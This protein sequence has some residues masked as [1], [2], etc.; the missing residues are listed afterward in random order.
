MRI[1][2]SIEDIVISRRRL[3]QT[4]IPAAALSCRPARRPNILLVLADDQ[5]Y[6]HAGAHGARNIQTPS[7][8]GIARQGVL[9][10]RSFCTSP[11]CTPSR[12]SIL[13]G[14]YPWQVEQAG[15]LYGTIPPKYPIVTH[16]LA[17][18]GYHAGFTGKGWGPGDWAA[19][20]LTRH[21]N[22]K[23]YNSRQHSIAPHPG[24]DPRDYASN[25]SDFLR[26]RPNG[27]PFFFWL[28]SAE[29][30]R[31]YQKGS[32]LAAGHQLGE[33]T[34]PPYWPD[35]PEVR[36]D[37]LDYI[38]EIEWFDVQ[39]AR[40][41]GVLAS[42]GELENTLIVVTSDNGMPFVRSKVNLYDPGV[43]MPLAIRW[44]GRVAPGRRVSDF[45]QHTDLAPTF[46]AAAGLPIPPSISG[47]SLLPI[48]DSKASGQIEPSRDFA[49]TGM[50]RH[51]MAR[52]DGATYPMR[53][54][55][56]A[57]YLYI[58][59]FAPDRWPTGGPDFLSSNRTPHGDVDAA[60]S[61]DFMMLPASQQ[62]YPEAFALCF[63]KRPA[64]EL[65]RLSS[66]PD[67][68]QNL[69]AN[70]DQQ[71]ALTA[72]R[73]RLEALLRQSS[74]PRIEG[75]DP[76]Q[77]YPYRQTNGFGASFNSTLP[78]ARRQAARQ[79]PRHKPE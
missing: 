25:F 54:L 51:V 24:L 35:T 66:D 9:F 18:A 43:H 56:T 69:A 31:P 76:W 12:S 74:D 52:P 28:G 61:A 33:V 1:P 77:A 3:L 72:H 63:G 67:Q 50:E 22:G 36:G 48:L 57:D 53:A 23:E 38:A 5:S 65:Y 2:D 73:Q 7:F 37:I 47:R 39:L 34:V 60:P 45:V 75:K 29:P 26:E 8:D 16:L 79:E 64:E 27:A 30:H 71:S 68:I 15:V 4:A 59:N 44:G 78:E 11:S 21:P 55:R 49:I 41:L 19:A 46:L 62:Q 20:G 17:D 10:D 42:A 14:R 32:G 13:T 58:R 40:T 70:P 6:P